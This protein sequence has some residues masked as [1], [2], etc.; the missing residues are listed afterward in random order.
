MA[1]IDI[2]VWVP[3]PVEHVGESPLVHRRWD[4][5]DPVAESEDERDDTNVDKLDDQYDVDYEV[6][7]LREDLDRF[8]AENRLIEGDIRD[9]IRTRT[10]PGRPGKTTEQ[11]Y[12]LH[13]S[14]LR[15]HGEFACAGD[16][17]ALTFCRE[18]AAEMV[19]S[20]GIS[21][22]EAV[23]RI[24]RQWSDPGRSARTPRIW[25]VGIDLVYH[26]TPQ[27]WAISTR[28]CIFAG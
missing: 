10:I 12:L 13:E 27:Y 17:Q 18:I 21:L 15:S 28:Q 4:Q 20:Y 5:P 8:L 23:A 14:A 6:L 19:R 3:E 24:N 26:E 25:I 2:Q 1:K 22:D 7:G 9:R 16:L 11:L